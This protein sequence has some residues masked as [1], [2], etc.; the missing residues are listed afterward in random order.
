V[1][2]PTE[3]QT[4][5]KTQHVLKR[6]RDVLKKWGPLLKQVTWLDRVSEHVPD[7]YT[8]ELAKVFEFLLPWRTAEGSRR[9]PL[10][11][12]ASSWRRDD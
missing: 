10:P 4:P 12:G 9:T 1:L 5:P 3:K 11:S 6:S 7:L 8:L 2:R